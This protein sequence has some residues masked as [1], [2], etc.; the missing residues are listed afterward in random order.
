[1]SAL[2]EAPARRL[3]ATSHV[4]ELGSRPLLMG[5]VNASPDSFS[6]GGRHA[7]LDARV[8]LAERLLADGAAI[9]DV[10]GES[11]TTGRPPV[12]IEREIE[13][14]VPL[15]QRVAGGLGALVSV[16]TYKPGVARA[17][18]A[19]GAA[20]VNDVSGLRDPE[21]ASVCAETGAALVLMHT[22]AAPRERLQRADLYDDVTADVLA[23][24][25]ERIAVASAAGVAA[26][27]L[28]VDPGP[29]FAKT[30]AQTIRLLSEVERLHGLGRPL[31]LAISRKDFVGALTGRAPR[32]RLAGTLA[33]LA[34][35]LDA[36]GHIFRVHDVAAAADFLA[37]REALRGEALPSGDLALAEQL[38][39]ERSRA[40]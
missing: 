36:G 37:V 11:A 25:R 5:I 2:R 26:E 38:R 35:G 34:H 27:Q 16:D 21:L 4:I 9:I 39:H 1:V 19:A 15:V 6:D 7:T 29:D 24:L 28:I 33:A 30:P 31:L 22:R 8:A 18:I 17:A 10:G 32:E 3:R 14:V 40:S 20:I 13:L 12:E 23:F